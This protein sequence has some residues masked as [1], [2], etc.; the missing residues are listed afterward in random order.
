MPVIRS[1]I[2]TAG[3]NWGQARASG[4]WWRS[5]G[6][7]GGGGAAAPRRRASATPPAA[8]CCPAS[9]WRLLDPGSPFLEVGQLAAFGMYDGE[10]PAPGM[11]TGI[12]RVAAAR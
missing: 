11:I 10:A 8:S 2:S 7:G 9:G 4:R 3:P 1:E 5:F 6:T 12:G